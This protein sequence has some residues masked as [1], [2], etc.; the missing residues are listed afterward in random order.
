[1]TPV[2]SQP[3]TKQEI[4]AGG[5]GSVSSPRHH[6]T[7]FALVP[8]GLTVA[9]EGLAWLTGNVWLH[10][11]AALSAAVLLAACLEDPRVTGLTVEI[12]HPPTTTVGQSTT[13]RMTITNNGRRTTSAGHLRDHTHGLADV[14]VLLPRLAPG[15]RSVVEV[16]RVATARGVTPGHAALVSSSAPYGLRLT[17]ATAQV[18]VPVV[19]WPRLLDVPA[20]R[21]HE[22]EDD[23]SSPAR[24]ARDGSA[25]RGL[26]DWR[27][28][29][30]PR[31][32]HWRA[33]ARR[34]QLVVREHEIPQRPR[35][36]FLVVGPPDPSTWEDE[37]SRLASWA[38]QGV[39]AGHAVDLWAEQPGLTPITDATAAE[40]LDWCAALR[41]PGW[42][43]AE[44]LHGL[45]ATSGPGGHVLTLPQHPPADPSSELVAQRLAAHGLHAEAVPSGAR[46]PPRIE[47]GAR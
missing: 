6:Y 26:R 33:S 42:P 5:S 34:G 35:L 12:E 23:D 3:S 2:R 28:G 16:T 14:S 31:Q 24:L 46:V 29:D 30:E 11:L 10:V 1:M 43:S 8:V 22:R 27:G 44:L 7:R 17:I 37:I 39:R 47:A 20:I 15:E 45:A 9:F 19:V 18:M 13:H 32:V 25:V 36:S 38:L 40:V 21:P 4:S 41:E